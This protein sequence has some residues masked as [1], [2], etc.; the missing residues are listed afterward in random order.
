MRPP[1]GVALV[2]DDDADART[3]YD[4]AL[5][6]DGFDVV[7]AADGEQALA[8]LTEM[9]AATIELVV[10]LRADPATRGVPV[11]MVSADHQAGA[12]QHLVGAGAFAVLDKPV[13]V[14]ELLAIVDECCPDDEDPR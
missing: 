9:V 8:V 12:R 1:R 11:A 14:T 6:A 3:M 10:Q 13:V 5:R 7:G 2:V 4:R